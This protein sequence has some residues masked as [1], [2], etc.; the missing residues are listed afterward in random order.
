MKKD[1]LVSILIPARNEEANIIP[2]LKEIIQKVKIPYEILVINDGS[3]DKTVEKVEGLREKDKRIRLF[4]TKNNHGFSAAIKLGLEKAKGLVVVP[5]MGDLCDEPTTI[6]LMYQR[7]KNEDFD[8]VCGSRYTSGGKKSGGP[9][10]QGLFSKLVCLYLYNVTKVPTSDITNAFKMY[11]KDL[12]KKVNFNPKSGVELSMELVL[13]AHFLH[14]AKIVDLPTK[15][16]GRTAGSSKFKILQRAP[17]YWRICA[18]ATKNSLRK[19]FGVAPV[20]FYTDATI[21]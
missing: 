3:T 20:R 10:F 4:N 1:F 7:M 8:I 6:N 14:S 13:Q 11:R 16:R 21:N 5:V 12:L 17:R 15:W 19:T 2:T 18:W 9:K